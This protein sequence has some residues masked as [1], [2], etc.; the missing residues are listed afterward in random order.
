[1]VCEVEAHLQSHTARDSKPK[2]Q[3]SFAQTRC[4]NFVQSTLEKTKYW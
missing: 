2:E 4:S 1:M 3:P